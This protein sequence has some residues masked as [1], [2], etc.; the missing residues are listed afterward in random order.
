[1]KKVNTDIALTYLLS[2]KKMTLVAILGVLVGMSI[3]IFMNSILVGF[4]R[5]SNEI[6]FDNTPHIRVF[7][8]D[9]ISQPL[10]SSPGF[11]DIIINPKIIP[12]SNVISNPFQ[13]TELIQK[14]DFVTIA[15]PQIST[16]VFYQK[17][18]SQISGLAIG[19]IPEDANQM[20]NIKDIVVEGNF[21]KLQHDVN[22]IALGNSVAEKLSISIGDNIHISSASGIGRNMKVVAIFKTFKGHLDKGK[23]YINLAA[24][25]Q[26]LKENANYITDINVHVKDPLHVESKSELLNNLTGYKSESWKEANES[27]LAGYKMRSIV[28][29]FVSIM[30]LIVAGFGIYNILNITV[31]QK[32]NDIAIL[33]AI[34]FK[35]MD[36]IKIFLT[37]AL[38]IG[39]IGV[40]LGTLFAIVG[41]YFLKQVYIGGDIGYFP[42][43]YEVSKFIQGVIIGIIITFLAGFIPAYKASGIDP[44]AIFRK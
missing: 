8:E 2:G 14:Q 37:Q 19:V 15:T 23:S 3:F 40:I 34:G 17:G 21:D 41:I 32:I 24:A 6:M 20:Y 26:L 12:S 36:V 39:I 18:K 11:T 33:K 25:Q 10:V 43:D 7:N 42:I 30:I 9:V 16:T 31:S 1:M 35:G 44:I 38:A 22:A 4:D 13:L 29:R 27:I 5:I 28:I